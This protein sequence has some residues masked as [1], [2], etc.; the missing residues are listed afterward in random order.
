V[1][2]RKG[3][4]VGFPSKL[5]AGAQLGCHVVVCVKFSKRGVR[6]EWGKGGG[7]FINAGGEVAA[8]GFEP[9][10]Y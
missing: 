2:T 4:K 9:G 6:R 3:K 7:L 10:T 5:A 1:F 8:A